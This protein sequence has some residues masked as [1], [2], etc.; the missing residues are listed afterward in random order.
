MGNESGGKVPNIKPREGAEPITISGLAS[1]GA[2]PN[3]LR[4]PT[5]ERQRTGWQS[6]EAKRIV[7]AYPDRYEMIGGKNCCG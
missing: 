7:A 3:P 6:A 4:F 1:V 2:N 5:E